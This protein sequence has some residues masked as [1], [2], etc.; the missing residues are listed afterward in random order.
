CSGTDLRSDSPMDDHG[1]RLRRIEEKLDR[2]LDRESQPDDAPA[3][4]AD[5]DESDE[6]RTADTHPADLALSVRNGKNGR[7]G[8]YVC[9]AEIGNYGDGAASRV[10]WWLS[11]EEGDIISTVA[12]GDEVRLG[13][14]E[15]VELEVPGWE[16]F[17]VA[18]AWWRLAWQ[19]AEGDHERRRLYVESA[20]A[21]QRWW[22]WRRPKQ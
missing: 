10:R 16:K 13:P 8:M 18:K 1:E 3:D 9:L 22:R 20:A 2:L 4:A 17:P 19:D 12:G 14:R 21:T 11:T 6:H 15:T 5:H 7:D